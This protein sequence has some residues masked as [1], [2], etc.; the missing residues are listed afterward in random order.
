MEEADELCDAKEPDHIAAEAADLIYFALTKCV[1]AG[2][3]LT[4]IERHLDLRSRKIS[5]RP[6]NAKP[7]WMQAGQSSTAAMAGPGDTK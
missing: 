4:D 1:K 3:S 2:V 6:G 5:R 7:K